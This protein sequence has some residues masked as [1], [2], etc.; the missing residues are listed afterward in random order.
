MDFGVFEGRTY[1][2]MEQDASYRA[3][4]DGDCAG[5]C[6]GGESLQEFCDRVCGAFAQ[7]VQES[8]G[9]GEIAVV[10]H[11]G[12]LMGVMERFALPEKS[13]FQWHVPCGGG[14]L[15]ETAGDDWDGE[16][17]LRLLEELRFGKDDGV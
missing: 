9:C 3:W 2:E 11:G 7:V 1:K 12:V 10:A 16:S 15:L 4:V 8:R 5:R 6:P 13:Y 14:F 17:R